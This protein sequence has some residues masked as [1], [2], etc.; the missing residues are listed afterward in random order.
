MILAFFAASVSFAQIPEQAKSQLSATAAALGE[1][2]DVPVSPFTG[3]PQVEIPLYEIQ[4]GDHKFP[5]SLSYHGGGVRPDQVP[6]WV[7]QGWS[8]NAGGCITR[9][10][11][12]QPDEFDCANSNIGLGKSQTGFMYRHGYLNNTN[13]NTTSFMVNTVLDNNAKY[14]DTE[15]DEFSFNFLDYHGKFYMGADGEWKVLC[16]RPIKVVASDYLDPFNRMNPNLL[17]FSYDGNNGVPRCLSM[18]ELYG[19]DGTRYLFGETSE[20]MEFSTDFVSPHEETFWSTAWNLKLI[21]YPDGR[22]I[23]LTYD[24]HYI[25]DM[26]PGEFTTFEAQLGVSCSQ[27]LSCAYYVGS[28]WDDGFSNHPVDTLTRYQGCLIRPSYL[29]SIICG[30]DT[31]FFEREKLAENPYNMQQMFYPMFLHNYLEPSGD[32]NH[33]WQSSDA[34]SH[35]LPMVYSFSLDMD[36]KEQGMSRPDQYGNNLD[37]YSALKWFKLTD[38]T[39]VS[40]NDVLKRYS[41]DYS[42]PKKRLFLNKVTEC[43]PHWS[44]GR[45][46]KMTYDHP[47][48]LPVFAS[49]KTDHWGFYNGQYANPFFPYTYHNYREPVSSLATIGALTR[50]DYPTGGFTRFEYEPHDYSKRVGL[51][52]QTCS[53]ETGTAGGIRIRRIVSKP[54]ENADS[55]VKEYFYV[56]G[57][58]PT[59]NLQNLP[60]SGVLASNPEYLFN[61]YQPKSLNANTTLMLSV[62]STQ[63][64][65]AGNENAAGCH[66]GY[67]EV[68][69]RLGDGSVTQYHF[70]NFDNG[71]YG[72]RQADQ[73]TQTAHVKCE[74]FT[75]RM[76]LRGR[77]LDKTEYRNQNG[78][79]TPHRVMV[80]TYEPNCNE[81]VNYARA[82]KVRNH[83]IPLGELFNEYYV[84][85]TECAA[86]RQHVSQLR[87][88]TELITENDNSGTEFTKSRSYT[89]NADNLLSSLSETGANGMTF[90]RELTYPSTTLKSNMYNA[91]IL[92]AVLE[93]NISR[94]SGNN[95]LPVS[96]TSYDYDLNMVRPSSIW[97]AK[98]NNTLEKRS[99]YLF[100]SYYNPIQETND[101]INHTVYVW[102][103]GGRYIVATVENATVADVTPVLGD[104]SAFAQSDTPN[105]TNLETLRQSLTTAKVTTYRYRPSVG[106][107]ET[108]APDGRSTTYEYDALGR[109][110]L[111][112]DNDGNILKTYEYNYRSNENN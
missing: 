12:G 110:S 84:A 44:K 101:G 96:R 5:I 48:S 93:E 70:S 97:Q 85:Y 10:V 39:V 26:P 62:F 100:D 36:M 77:L 46:Y 57:F 17:S 16:D 50:I 74:P 87:P 34:I 6:G 22:R 14:Y 37:F 64:V 105:F 102:G 52:H 27:I 32:L 2:G 65:V 81:S 61:N 90:V 98:G 80:S 33:P 89:Y 47:E 78:Q 109:L 111:I 7:G 72:D 68:I 18:F 112:R 94:V 49:G 58:T 92:S 1:Y 95:I 28:I 25:G 53:P 60:S 75:S 4:C 43:S 8:L 15:P 59:S 23:E 71:D 35:F 31:V 3:V 63:S 106:L 108:V 42:V 104:L 79:L 38:I 51:D 45:E 83:V 67:S 88:I 30:K 24:D 20:C 29:R 107:V 99:E 13:W 69:E 9:V 76:A 40:G 86:Y 41:F 11:K 54:E 55:I 21:V 66:V 56:R 82:I 19:E 103:Y 91:H 73:V